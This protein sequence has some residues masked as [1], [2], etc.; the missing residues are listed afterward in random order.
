MAGFVV[1]LNGSPSAGKTTL[2]EAVQ[3]ASTTPLFH[4]SLDDFLAGYL[5]HFREPDDGNLFDRVRTGYVQSL[6][7]L[8]IAG[9]DIVAEAV[10][11]PESVPLYINAFQ[12]VPVMLVGV[13]CTL[14]VAQA[15]EQ[16]RTDRSRLDL[17]V[18]WFETVHQ[19]PYDLEIDTASGIAVEAL[20]DQVLALLN[21]PPATRAFDLLVQRE[22][23]AD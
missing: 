18:P 22:N 6:A 12:D 7:Q 13:R 1:L 15:R 9:N 3:K 14:E 11:I 10:I 2:A 8:A 21:D 16:A 19:I 17:D 20:S 4:R 5:R 23:A